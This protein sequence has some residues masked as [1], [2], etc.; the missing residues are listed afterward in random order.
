MDL[1]TGTLDLRQALQSDTKLRSQQVDV[2]T[3]LGQE[4]THGAALLVE[5]CNHD[6]GGLDELVIESYGERLRLSQR[7][8]K[9][10]CQFVHSHCQYLSVA[11]SEAHCPI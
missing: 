8:L 2:G 1:A 10:A 6:V 5:Q 4:S 9:F 3:R 11:G 7:H